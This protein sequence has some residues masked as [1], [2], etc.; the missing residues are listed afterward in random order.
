VAA[1]LKKQHSQYICCQTNMKAKYL[2]IAIAFIAAACNKLDDD[3]T[4]RVL[5]G[6]KFAM[7]GKWQAEYKIDRG[8][9]FTIVPYPDGHVYDFRIGSTDSAYYLINDTIVDRGKITWG[10]NETF[11]RGTKL[12]IMNSEVLPSVAV[13]GVLGDSL[14]LFTP[15]NDGTSYVFSKK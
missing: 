11:I 12:I 5:E 15:D 9:N 3:S 8:N 7:P 1:F 10:S 14:Y 13:K 2:I 4:D 6:L